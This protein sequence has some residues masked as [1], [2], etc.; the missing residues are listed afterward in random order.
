MNMW[1]KYA[2]EKVTECGNSSV[3]YKEQFF[4]HGL[5]TVHVFN[6]SHFVNIPSMGKR[7]MAVNLYK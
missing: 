3:S 1:T 6:G 7:R 5:E 4:D 2:N